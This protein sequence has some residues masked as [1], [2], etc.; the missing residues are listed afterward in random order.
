M[1]GLGVLF[2]SLYKGY[3]T[4]AYSLLFGEILGISQ[5]SVVITLMAGIVI[6][7]AI[8]CI[9]RPLLFSS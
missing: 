4:E 2:I 1:L 7:I 6:L 3:A 9:Y 8:A 5:S